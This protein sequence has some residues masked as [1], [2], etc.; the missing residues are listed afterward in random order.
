MEVAPAAGLAVKVPEPA[1]AVAPMNNSPFP[2]KL[3]IV[4]CGPLPRTVILRPYRFTLA[5]I[6]NV[7]VS[8]TTCRSLHEL[9]AFWMLATSVAATPVPVTLAHG[10]VL[11]GGVHGFGVV[12]PSDKVAGSPA[13]PQSIAR[14]DERILDHDWPY[15]TVESNS[16]SQ[17]IGKGCRRLIF[18][19]LL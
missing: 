14:L 12:S 16:E 3:R 13:V 4:L 19:R 6:T 8:R 7:P 9:T 15:E 17:I 11:V 18:M 10:V 2:V 1:G 5:L